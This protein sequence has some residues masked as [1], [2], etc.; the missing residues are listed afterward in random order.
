MQPISRNILS[1]D[2]QYAKRTG[3][4]ADGNGI[5]ATAVS[6]YFVRCEPVK[7]W[8]RN[9]DGEMKDD[10]LTMFYDCVNSDPSS[11][12]FKKGDK[13]VFKNEDYTVREVKDFSPHHFEVILK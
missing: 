1:H 10:K 5:Y 6:I 11:A 2:V 3:T 12:N 7:S 9:T 8:L 13:V 4:D